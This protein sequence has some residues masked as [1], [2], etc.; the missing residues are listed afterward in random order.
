MAEPWSAQAHLLEY[1]T[2]VK[3]T[4]VA[5]VAIWEDLE[6]DAQAQDQE[7]AETASQASTL[8]HEGKAAALNRQ[9]ALQER[10]ESTTKETHKIKAQLN[11][12]VFKATSEV[13]EWQ[14]SHLTTSVGPLCITHRR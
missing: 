9:A 10:I 4:K 12:E 14:H 6:V 8:W 1:G 11:D 3:E 2:T 5:L 13:R 7:L